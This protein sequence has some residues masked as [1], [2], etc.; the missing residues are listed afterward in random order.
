METLAVVALLL[1]V[2]ALVAAA[3]GLWRRADPGAGHALEVQARS[4]AQIQGALAELARRHEDLR[5]D[6]QRL[7]S[8]SALGLSQAAAGIRV[9]VGQARTAL[10]EVKAL[11]QARARSADEAAARLRRLEAVLAGS[12]TRG[13]AGE[14]ILARALGQ[15]PPDLIEVNVA[16][17]GR[18]VEYA[19]RLPGGR[20]LPIDSKWTSVEPLAR[21]EASQDPLERQ[22]LT[23]QITRELALRARDLAKYLDPERTAA[24][25]VLAVPDAVHSLALDVQVKAYRDG[26]L[27][28]PYS[29]AL[30]YV[31]ALLRL[32]GRF[33]L[34]D[35]GGELARRLTALGES[36]RRMDDEVEG[37]L[38]RALVQAENA[39]DALRG[40]LAVARRQ[41]EQLVPAAEAEPLPADPV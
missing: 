37:R 15:L 14:N 19:L 1:G 28:V 35:E 12:A 22:R 33:S 20:L 18:V 38:S 13:A 31:L 26:V 6:V 27:V 9:E 10:A 40:S 34:A 3:V 17:G 8:E 25:A 32:A 4:L 29:L 11:E 2:V 41:A 7:H 21:L 23:E 39:R 36:L 30:P 24:L 5:L 16:F